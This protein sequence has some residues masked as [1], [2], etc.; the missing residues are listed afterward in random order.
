MQADWPIAVS[1]DRDPNIESQFSQFV[2]LLG[3]IRE[4]RSRQNLAPKETIEY[5]VRSNSEIEALLLPMRPLI[6]SMA[7]ATVQAWSRNPTLPSVQ[8]HIALDTMDVFV[9]LGK[10]IDVDAEIA[11]NEK[12]LENLIKQITAKQGKLTNESFVSRAPAD[13]VE[14]ERASL[15]DLTTQRDSAEAAL[16]TL[17]SNQK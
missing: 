6:Q 9:D 16:K 14:K 15:V 7:G 12:L 2:A 4:I 13:V 8:A 5:C 10:F 11:R 17:R 3:A 1:I